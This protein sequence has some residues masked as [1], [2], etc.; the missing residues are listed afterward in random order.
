MGSRTVVYP[1]TQ[2]PARSAALVRSAARAVPAVLLFA[3]A[4]FVVQRLTFT[5][6][7]PPYQ[8]ATIWTPG[9]L[10][11]AALLLAPLRRW[12]VYYVGLCLGAFAAFYGDPTVSEITI[13]LAVQLNFAA[14]ATGVWA[15]RRFAHGPPFESTGFVLAFVP[16]A[17]VLVP[18]LTSLPEDAS[19]LHSAA[20]DYWPV[21][22][23][24][25][26]AAALGVLIATPAFTLTVAN[27]L[28]WLHEATRWQYAELAC[29]L[30]ALTASG[31]MCF[32]WP[33]QA[34]AS[35]VLLCVP[36]PFLLWAAMRF[37]LSTVSWAL[38]VIA[39]Q[40]TRGAIRGNGPFA[41]QVPAESVLQVQFFLFAISLPL[42]FLAVVIEERRRAVSALAEREQELRN[43]YAQLGTI[44]HTAP[45]GLAFVDRG[46]R[47]VSVNDC[48]A[49][50]YG[51]P[52]DAHLGRTI[53]E[54]LPQFA[55]TVERVYRRVIETGE[56]VVDVE[57]RGTTASRPGVARDWLV[58]HYP[59]KDARGETLG[60]ST[61]VQ[62]ITERK[63]TEER[64]RLIVESAP[65]AIVVVDADG[66]VV[67]V[68]SQCER[69]FGYR[70][71]ELVGRSVEMLIPERFRQEYARLR[72]AYR[73]APSASPV[74]AGRELRGRHRDGTEIPVEIGLTPMQTGEGLVVLCAVVD[75]T[76]RKRAEEVRR[77]LRHASR[78]AMV[79]ELTAS[80]AHEINQPLGAILNNA[81]AAEMLLDASP[82]ALGEVRQ[83]LEDIRKDDL[84][85]SE[86]IR[87]LRNLLRK[88]EMEL[89]PVDLNDLAAEAVA[90]V[91][92]ES[93]RRG[94]AVEARLAAELPPVRGDRVHLQQVMLNLLLNGMEAMTD[95]ARE[96]R[97]TVRTSLNRDGWVEVAVADAGAG[98]PA[99]RLPRLFEPFFS[100][101]KEGMGLGLSIARSLVE[102]HGGRIRAANDPRGGAVF[103][104]ELP[105]AREEAGAVQ[106]GPE[107]APVR[108]G[109]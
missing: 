78:L 14:V 19:R 74:G 63:R 70:R 41:S 18:V 48:L 68:N 13:L 7:F 81:D 43:Q 87:R 95:V 96:K 92:A 69:L 83:I 71:R 2:P 60:V 94:V 5:L 84:R 46:L 66:R 4:F 50:L 61:V 36:L 108:A 86:V 77:E 1:G 109:A 12:W 11:F 82:P 72:A 62:E 104:F 16:F 22:L 47:F 29:L 79:G 23:R 33:A 75:V 28:T 27:G 76:E 106:R 39:I 15:V 85:A 6:R 105:A 99:D 32:E 102:A 35:P 100:T 30:F 55:D 64:F 65:N 42:M 57:L 73:A 58:S 3:A 89:Q 10:L 20:E 26:F 9:A 40:S 56:P 80:I 54:V 90:L 17:V 53:R 107:Q 67:L 52:A 45:V 8:R 49:D 31:F 25:L 44:Y 38:L 37:G 59:V 98:I 97:L 88:R 24:F 91:R 103:Q 51:L 21:A 101:K 34:R 93:R